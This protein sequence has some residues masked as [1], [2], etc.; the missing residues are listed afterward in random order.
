M[1]DG[2]KHFFT[3]FPLVF[4]VVF[5]IATLNI[6]VWLTLDALFVISKVLICSMISGINKC[7]LL[8]SCFGL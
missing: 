5:N 1:N 2:S 8:F 7:N 4:P 3:F 6:F